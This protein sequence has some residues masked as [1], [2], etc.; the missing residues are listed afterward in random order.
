VHKTRFE[1]GKAMKDIFTSYFAQVIILL[2]NFVG[3]VLA[4][5]LLLPVGRG[6]LG[7]VMLYPGLIAALGAFSIN[8]AI[9]FFT[10]SGRAAAP[11]VIG[12]AFGIGA[13][14]SLALMAA[15]FVALSYVDVNA[16]PEVRRITVFYLLFIPLG[17]ASGYVVSACQAHRRFDLW[18]LLRALM[19]L[20]YAAIAVV[21]WLTDEATVA[22]FAAAMLLAN[23]AVFVTG[24]VLLRR[25]GQFSMKPDVGVMKRML[26]YGFRIQIADLLTL[27]NYRVDQIV[28]TL[29]LPTADFGHYLVAVA[30]YGSASGLVTLLGSLAF[31][32][33]AAA[34]NDAARAETLGRYLRLALALAVSGGLV[35][36]LVA[37][38]LITLI[39]G[40][41]YLPASGAVQIFGAGIA[42]AA[43]KYLLAQT[44]K[45]V[46]RPL[47]IVRAEGIALC[48]NVAGVIILVPT[49][50]ILG[51]ALSLALAQTIACAALMIAVR[52]QLG[53][54]LLA[55]FTPSAGDISFVTRR[56]RE[57]LGSD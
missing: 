50:G 11:R 28:I 2:A 31:P 26:G 19:S 53:V 54:T 49:F 8:D 10:A 33:V 22:A 55:L 21:L 44:F 24:A 37:P 27:A 42:P 23:L 15:G 17:Y 40:K 9:I 32:K 57:I 45:A 18:N 35:L 13:A 1:F 41:A 14:L 34:E 16:S 25:L 36:V 3:G 12:S 47:T 48:A 20:T 56:L 46:G 5:R 38:W 30:V 7:Q 29:W 51:A 4:A 39:Y 52:R 43:C 6:E